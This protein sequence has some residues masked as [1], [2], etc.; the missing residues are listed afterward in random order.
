[1]FL[2]TEST[3]TVAYCSVPKAASS[4]LKYIFYRMSLIKRAEPDRHKNINVHTVFDYSKNAPSAATLHLGIDTMIRRNTI[5]WETIETIIVTVYVT[6]YPESSVKRN[7]RA[8][9][10]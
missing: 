2:L 9:K 6:I 5:C 8:F 7:L 10:S 3:K 1:M 4:T